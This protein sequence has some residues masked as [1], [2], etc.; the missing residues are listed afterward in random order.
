MKPP[1]IVDADDDDSESIEYT[2]DE[3]AQ[4][5]E[6]LKITPY[7]QNTANFIKEK[8]KLTSSYRHNT[9][10]D[11][12]VNIIKQ[13]P[14]MICQPDLVMYFNFSIFHKNKL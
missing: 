12:G 5:V 10:S 2:A 14:F 7:D 4:D 11:P 9:L 1:E 13:F 6:Y 3:A 8:L